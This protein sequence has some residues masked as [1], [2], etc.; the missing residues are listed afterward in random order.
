MHKLNYITISIILAVL[1]SLAG[2]S[3]AVSAH[4]LAVTSPTLGAAASYSVL[5]HTKVTNTGPTTLTGDLGVSPGSAVTGFPP[6]IVGPTGHIHKADGSAHDA[7]IDNSA[8]F[9][10]LDSQGY[11]ITYAGVQ[12]L[13]LVSPHG[14]GCLLRR[15]IHTD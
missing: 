6:S 1:L 10:F 8:A 14:P 5:A 2:L 9:G 11:T 12:D 3:F 15:L 7:Q 13:I 4:P